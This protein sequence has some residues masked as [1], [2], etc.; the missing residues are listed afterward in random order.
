MPW[1]NE[2]G[3][4]TPYTTGASWKT[5]TIPMTAFGNY[6]PSEA[7]DV[8]FQKIVEDRNAGSYRNFV[9]L[10]VNADLEFSDAITYKAKPFNQKIYID[11]L[12]VV[13]TKQI[14]VSDF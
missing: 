4:H 13:N 10:F 11:N 5:V 8:T 1:L 6:D 3:S 2:D 9:L 12:R 14:T 7:P